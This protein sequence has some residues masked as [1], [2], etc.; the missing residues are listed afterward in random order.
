[1]SE[2]SPPTL[3]PLNIADILDL[4]IRLYRQNFAAFL[5]IIAI[6]YVPVGIMQILFAF[7][8]GNLTTAGS[9]G[10]DQV[11]WAQLGTMGMAVGGLLLVNFL[12]IPLGQGALT[13]A[14]SRRYLNEP[15]TVADAYRFIG[16]RW[17]VLI[18]TVL[19]AAMV[20]MGGTVLCIVP[21]IYV[22]ILLVLVTPII[23]I[24]GLSPI[25]SMKRSAALVK[26]DWWRCF[27]T[28]AI[29]TLMVSF[30]TQAVAWPVA[31]ASMAFLMEKNMALAQA[32]NQGVSVAVQMLVQPVLITGLVLLYYDLR[33]RKEGFDLEL[34]AQAMGSPAPAYEAKGPLYSVPP[35][36]P[37]GWTS[38]P[39]PPPP[40]AVAP[41]AVPEWSSAPLPPPP[42]P[43]EAPAPPDETEQYFRP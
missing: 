5:G 19:L 41:G 6:V 33:V 17:G 2:Q 43:P 32:I 1:M 29:L 37:Q 9:Q 15:V 4:S 28:Y 24:E 38:A 18:G 3:R 30:I 20:V 27:G 16:P 22:A 36:V 35:P 12:A 10:P 7:T 11:P 42:A 39:P 40:P 21:G 8:M 13:I 26:D 14:V 25:D 34:L 31:M 23:V